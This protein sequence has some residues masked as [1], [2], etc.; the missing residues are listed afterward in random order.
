MAQDKIAKRVIS[1]PEFDKTRV[2]QVIHYVQSNFKI[3][4]YLVTKLDNNTFD[5]VEL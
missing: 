2:M 1:S 3:V 5:I 4:N